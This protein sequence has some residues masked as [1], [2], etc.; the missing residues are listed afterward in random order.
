ML[1]D[2]NSKKGGKA[3]KVVSR[4]ICSIMTKGTRTYCHLDDV[5]MLE[6]FESSSGSGVDNQAASILMCIKETSLQ[7]RADSEMQIDEEDRDEHRD[8]AVETVIEYGIVMVDTVLGAVTLAQFQDD[9][10]RSRLRT[11]LSR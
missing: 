9:A 3:D 6:D 11:M 7:A 2:R 1:K 8:G 4:E 10:Q 5:S